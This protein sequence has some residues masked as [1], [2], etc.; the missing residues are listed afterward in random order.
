[1]AVIASSTNDSAI[2][3]RVTA[4]MMA[5]HNGAMR[6]MDPNLYRKPEYFVYIYTVAQKALHRQMSPLF[7]N[8]PIPACGP[9]QRYRP[10]TRI[11]H[12]LPQ[13]ETDPHN[14]DD[15]ITYW[16]D[17]KKVAQDVCNPNN[18]GFDQDFAMR[19]NISR[20]NFAGWM[21]LG[22]G[23]NLNELGVFWSLNEKEFGMGEPLEEEIAAAEKRRDGYYR[24]I[25]GDMDRIPES[26]PMKKELIGPFHHLACDRFGEERPWHQS[27]AVKTD[28]PNCGSKIK[29]GI[30]YHMNDG[31]KCV[32]DPVIA[33][34]R[35]FISKA[36]YEDMMDF[37]PS[38]EKPAPKT[39]EK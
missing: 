13:I 24:Y 22:I 26:D 29:T 20:E 15:K 25:L 7:R 18:P 34:Q 30:A 2:A 31:A 3:K 35:G 23:Q 37:A 5:E 39:K 19:S 27:F 10:V 21:Q 6:N 4:S 12:P 36:E 33:R 28:C 9:G 8:L 32:L 38:P 11:A 16:H 17:G 14:P 1:M